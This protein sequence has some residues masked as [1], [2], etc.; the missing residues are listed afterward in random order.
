MKS[1]ISKAIKKVSGKKPFYTRADGSPE[2]KKEYYKRHWSD[3][4]KHENN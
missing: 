3:L 1:P 2:T 4:S